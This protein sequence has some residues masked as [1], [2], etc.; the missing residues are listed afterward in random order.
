MKKIF[1]T[2]LL[3]LFILPKVVNAGITPLAKVGDKYY[4]SLEEAILNVSSN[5]IITLISDVTLDNTLQI[6]K[7]VNI[8]LNGKTI[9]AAEKVFE[10]KGGYL[11]LSG[12]GTIKESKPKYGAV[13]LVGSNNVNDNK[14]SSVH[15]GKD[16]TLEG[17]SGIF[18]SHENS[19]S[20]GVVVYL[21]GK[22]NAVDDVDGDTGIGV[23]VNGNIKDKESNPVINISD[24]AQINSTGTGLYIAGYSNF[25]IGK[26][27]ITGVESGIGIKSGIL[28]INGA[29][30]TATGIDKTPTGGYNN[31]IKASGTAIQ[32]E[33]NNGYAGDIQINISN[34]K[35]TS[36]N[37]H[38]IYE[39]IGR[40]NSSLIYSMSFSNGT[41]IS[42]AGKNV[43]FFS[44]SF[45]DIHSGFISGGKYSSNPSEYLKS[46]YSTVNE[47]GI[48]SVTKNILKTV[49]GS[50]VD[51]NKPTFL[52][53]L[54]SLLTIILLGFIIYLNRMK[55]SNWLR[56]IKYKFK[57]S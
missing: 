25:Y 13:M 48:Y 39:Y 1:F 53:S 20:Y 37:S 54:I 34:G 26:A 18:I 23:Y 5:D 7:T 2:V 24:G 27:K 17:W 49:S 55:I 30:V 10:V 8:N 38:V 46:G 44:E 31:G 21:D 50:N 47:G 29:T 52:K 42:E 22:I 40:G 45:K 28:N 11:N 51:S 15:V 4:S 35:F 56:N 16:I 43:F 57:K 14:Y 12:S 9:V 36:K 41:F 32:I 19:K 33:S 6:N 3:S